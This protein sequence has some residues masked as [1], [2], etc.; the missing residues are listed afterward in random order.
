MRSPR[1]VICGGGAIG[2]AIAYF[3]AKRGAQ[4]VVVERNAVGGAASGKSGG[5]LAYDWCRGT[6]VDRLARRSFQLHAE[7]ADELGN[8]WGYRR[9]TTFAGHATA[10]VETR[11]APGRSW[12][13]QSVTLTG[14][15]GTPETTALVEPHAFTTGLM[16]AAEANGA[17]LKQGIVSG[18][19]RDPDGA[20]RGVE[21]DTGEEIAGDAVVIALGPWSILA[22]N[23]L[24]IPPVYGFKGHSLVFRTGEAIPAEALFLEYQEASGEVLTPEVFARADGTVWAC[25]V[26]STS[27]LPIDPAR[28]KGDDGVHERLEA[29]CRSLSPAIASAPIVAK[30][31]CFRPVTESGVPLIG[32]VPGVAN[33]YVATGH[34]VWGMLNSPATGEAMAELIL[35]GASTHVDLARFSPR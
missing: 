3:L 14:Q 24:P 26:S 27:P 23:W 2:T 16:R 9:L 6:P 18:L 4:P 35:D 21:L 12:L 13:S 17:T 28:V 15:I 30:Q 1:I 22:A 10:G 34:S 33:A 19:V 7:L 8:P 11:A 5:F 29:L 20:V 25:A 31:A 32:A